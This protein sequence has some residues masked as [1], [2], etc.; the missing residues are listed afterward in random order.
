MIDA[1]LDESGIHDGAPVCVIAGYFGGKGQW[2]KFELLW[3][4][5]LKAAKMQL[6]DFHAKNLI[7]SR[8]NEGLLRDLATAIGEYKVHPVSVAVIVDDFNSFSLG[9]RRFLTGGQWKNGKFV[10]S[11]SPSKPYFLP[12]QH[13]VSRVAE[14]VPVGGKAHFSF[15]LDRSF[16]GY[17][18]E[19]FGSIKDGPSREL[20]SEPDFPPAKETPQLQAADLLVHLTYLDIQEK[21]ASNDWAKPV[22]TLLKLCL[23]RARMKE[24]FVYFNKEGIQMTL[25][26]VSAAWNK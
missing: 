12:F 13:C 14:Y 17:A 18:V 24:D 26:G 22:P 11:G 21:M 6:A 23:R 4:K 9:Q 1:Y 16:A 25:A 3:R 15:G 19:L 7:K 5:T 10:T 2:K 8:A 20:L